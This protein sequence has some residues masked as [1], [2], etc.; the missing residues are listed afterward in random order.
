AAL[1]EAYGSGDVAAFGLAVLDAQADEAAA[2]FDRLAAAGGT[3]HREASGIGLDLVAAAGYPPAAARAVLALVVDHG[4][5]DIALRARIDL[6][7]RLADI[8]DPAG[9]EAHLRE[10]IA[11][12]GP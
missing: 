10:V 5:P 12:G 4:D 3:H 2:V 9:A 6:A 11:H 7:S 8:D 1:T